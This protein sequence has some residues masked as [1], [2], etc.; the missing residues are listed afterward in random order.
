MKPWRHAF[1]FAS[2]IC[3]EIILHHAIDQVVST[4]RKDDVSELTRG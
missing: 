2:V 3:M 4:T 1:I